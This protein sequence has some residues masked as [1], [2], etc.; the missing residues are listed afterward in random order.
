METEFI[1]EIANEE[2]KIVNIMAKNALLILDN[3][4]IEMNRNKNSSSLVL[5][6]MHLQIAIEL[7]IKNYI[8]KAYGF[9]NILTNKFKKMRENDVK[10]Y[11]IELK[12]NNIKTLGFNDLKDVLVSNGDYFG[13]V[14]KEGKSYLYNSDIEYDYLEGLFDKFQDIRNN[15]VHLGIDL[16]ENDI[17]WINSEFNMMIIYF[18]STI[19]DKSEKE[20]IL[21]DLTYMDF[22]ITSID[23]LK[24]KLSEEARSILENSEEFQGE[25]ESIAEDISEPNEALKCTKCG[26]DTLALNIENSG[27][28]TK[29]LYCGFQFDAYYCECPTCKYNTVVYDALNIEVNNNV[30]PGYCYKCEEKV[31]VYKCPICGQVYSYDIQHPIHFKSKCCKNNYQDREIMDID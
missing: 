30:M 5:G 12:N 7:Y 18:L 9:E 31:K 21:E 13:F 16:K 26:K 6:A 28:Q 19:M 27:G 1:N 23:I 25:L 3:S 4:I 17:K 14:I 2:T 10:Q 8:C 29:C 22:Y 20:N 11:Y 15:F 24:S